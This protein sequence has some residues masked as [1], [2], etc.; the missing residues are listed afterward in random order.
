MSI[1]RTFSRNGISCLRLALNW[2][3]QRISRIP[4]FMLQKSLKFVEIVQSAH[5]SINYSQD[6]YKVLQIPVDASLD[7]IQEA[8][9]IL[10]QQ[11]NPMTHPDT[12]EAIQQM[13]RINEAYRVLSSFERRQKYDLGL[14]NL[15]F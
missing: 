6:H 14:W 10:T 7:D 5:Y 13:K 4:N 11:Y 9:G 1:L 12:A 15:H 3:Q 2:E 8:Y